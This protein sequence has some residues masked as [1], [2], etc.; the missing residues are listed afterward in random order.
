MNRTRRIWHFLFLLGI[1]GLPVGCLHAENASASLSN[2]TLGQGY[3]LG[4]SGLRLGGYASVVTDSLRGQSWQLGVSDLSLFVMWEPSTRW[5]FFS[6]LELADALTIGGNGSALTTSDAYFDAERLYLDFNYSE[7]VKFRV[8]KFLTPIGRWNLIHADPLVWTTSRPIVTQ[9]PFAFHATGAM[10]FGNFEAWG[11]YWDYALYASG[12]DE[13]DFPP[14]NISLDR[15]YQ[16]T[17]GFRLTH[18]LPGRLGFG[19]SYAHFRQTKEQPGDKNLFGLDFSWIHNRFETSGEFVYRLGDRGPQPNEWGLYLQGVAPLTAHCYAI[20]RYETYQQ[21]G[22]NSPVHR[23][24]GGLAYRPL[25]PLVFKVE[26]SWGLH[27]PS[28]IPGR[29]TEGVT[30]GFPEGFAASIAIL[31]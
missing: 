14:P 15:F 16:D 17:V 27:N 30:G 5:R 24:V 19:V 12:P 22:A 21:E 26:Y 7:P 28:E 4:A 8:G 3:N 31:F 13:L 29:F 25:P 20:G 2:Y 23:W 1:W 18:E 6:E 11:R 10:L 9:G